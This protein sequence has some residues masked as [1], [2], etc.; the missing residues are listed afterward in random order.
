MKNPVTVTILA[1]LLAIPACDGGDKSTT[2]DSSTADTPATDASATD[3][4]TTDTPTTDTPTTDAPTTDAE[5]TD[6]ETTATGSLSFAADIWDP[7][8]S[9]VCSCH[10]GGSGGLTMGGDA[11]TAYAAMVGVKSTGSDLN[12]IEA[13]DVDASYV[14]HKLEGTQIEAGGNGGKMPLAGSV[15]AEQ[16]QTIKDWVTQ[17]AAP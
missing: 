8:F 3:A 1:A 17:G 6:G 4:P 9:P 7:I 16:I 14:I 15:T 12:Y 13:G 5:T 10:A 11:A 2:D